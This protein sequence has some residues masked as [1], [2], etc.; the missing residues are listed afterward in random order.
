MEI[1]PVG[2]RCR[3]CSARFTGHLTKVPIAVIVKTGLGSMAVGFGYGCIQSALFGGF[4][5]WF[6]IYGLGYAIGRGLHK[7][8]NHKL[9]YKVI[10]TIVSG[11]LIGALLSPARDAMLGRAV[12][13]DAIKFADEDSDINID[14]STPEGIKAAYA[15]AHSQAKLG[16]PKFEAAFKEHLGDGF[17]GRTLIKDGAQSEHLW[18]NVESIDGQKI[19]GRLANKPLEL[20]NIK[21][22]APVSIELNQ[23]EDWYYVDQD[24]R[25][26]G[27]FTQAVQAKQLMRVGDGV[28]ML[29][30]GSFWLTFAILMA[31]VLSPIL[32]VRIRN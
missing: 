13:F 5:M 26:V 12:T 22:G 1:C 23:L 30:T 27:G 15:D 25:E 21:K 18:F 17:K 3:K 31:G 6:V 2:N 4:F 11:M 7:L 8:A 19:T 20:T 10:A 29:T 28:G 32:R 24:D 9:G 14:V 16:F